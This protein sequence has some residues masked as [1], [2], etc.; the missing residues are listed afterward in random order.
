MDSD[1]SKVSYFVF[2]YTHFF[3]INGTDTTYYNS[4]L[5]RHSLE[6]SFL[7]SVSSD[8]LEFKPYF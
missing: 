1:S 6:F 2:M 8:R 7:G 3:S 4:Y 5:K